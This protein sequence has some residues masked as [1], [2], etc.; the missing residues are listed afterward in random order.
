MTE[1]K[2]DF[3]IQS[4]I[5]EVYDLSKNEKN[6]LESLRFKRDLHLSVKGHKLIGNLIYDFYENNSN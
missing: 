1:N 3:K 4:L 6:F 2:N 5:K